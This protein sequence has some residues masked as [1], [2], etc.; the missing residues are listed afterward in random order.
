MYKTHFKRC[1]DFTLSLV[2]LP[3]VIIIIIIVT[4]LIFFEDYKSVFYVSKRI[5]QNGKLFNMYKLRT[6]YANSPDYRL[7]DGSTF[8]SKFD[9]RVTKIG[10]FLRQYSLD[11]LPQILNVIIGNMSL[12]GPRPDPA[13]WIEKYS[14]EDREFLKVKP[15]ISGYNQAYFRN[16]SNSIEKIKNDIYYAKNLSFI[17]DVKIILKTFDTIFSRDNIYTN[18]S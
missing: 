5:G 4:P 16:S 8:N 18:R 13:D 9:K 14:D 3:F 6:M 11:E 15:G 17:F 10:T 2:I 7:I 12:I 1:F